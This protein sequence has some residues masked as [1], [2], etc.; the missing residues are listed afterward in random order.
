MQDVTLIH[1]VRQRLAEGS[2]PSIEQTIAL[3]HL[4]EERGMLY[5]CI[6][7]FQDAMY[8]AL[9]RCGLRVM[10]GQEVSRSMPWADQWNCS[11]PVGGFFTPIE[12]SSR[13]ACQTKLR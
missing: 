1:A 4:V 12:A 8:T 5:T 2:S 11:T 7:Q 13:T 6:G 3:L 9:E 10:C